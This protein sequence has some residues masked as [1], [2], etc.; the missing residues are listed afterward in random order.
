MDKETEKAD[1]A[2]FD[3][4]KDFR[5]RSI[6]SSS[7]SIAGGEVML[8]SIPNELHVEILRWLDLPSICTMSF[9]NSHFCELIDT[10]KDS[11]LRACLHNVEC[12]GPHAI[13][14]KHSPPPGPTYTFPYAL[15][16]HNTRTTMTQVAQICTL[17][18]SAK[19]E[20]LY[21]IRQ[22]CAKSVALY[23]TLPAVITDAELELH[24]HNLFRDYT[25]L[26]LQ[27]MAGASIRLVFK[28]AQLMGHQ[29]NRSTLHIGVY[30]RYNSYLLANGPELI[31]ELARRD[32]RGRREYLDGL[33]WLG[34]APRLHDEIIRC[35]GQRGNGLMTDPGI[36]IQ[37]FFQEEDTI[38]DMSVGV[39][40]VA[41]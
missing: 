26:Q 12:T 14:L 21:C 29:F 11:I 37:Q 40:F 19:V 4:E 25:T 15:A 18:Q 28:L 30:T 5:R 8:S 23:S 22:I 1:Q 3:K 6:Q 34:D 39:D 36:E 17:L 16:T 13:L 32:A 7:S 20:A 2:E 38:L 27:N 9:V 33:D 10:N 24:R 41:P 35:L 31:V